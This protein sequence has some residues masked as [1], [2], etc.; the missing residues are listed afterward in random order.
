MGEN[1]LLRYK[2]SVFTVVLKV[3]GVTTRTLFE[4]FSSTAISGLPTFGTVTA[5]WLPLLADRQPTADSATT[6][7]GSNSS[8][9]SLLCQVQVQV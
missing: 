1:V 2:A 3:K 4:K 6:V 9:S 7:Q 5:P 8:S